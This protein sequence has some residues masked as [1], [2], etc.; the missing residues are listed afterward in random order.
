MNSCLR[1]LC[2]LF[3]LVLLPVAHSAEDTDLRLAIVLT[4][5][6][7][8]TPLQANEELD[9]YSGKPWP[10]W[11]LPPGMLTA[12]GYRQMV[13]MG[14][15]YR[16][17]YVAAGLLSGHADLDR[18]V[19]YFNADN[20]ARTIASAQGIAEGLM[21]GE[22]VA[23]AALPQGTVD[24][25][26]RPAQVP[27]GNPDRQLA[28]AAVLGSVGGD[29]ANVDRTWAPTLHDLRRVVYGPDGKLPPGRDP[30]LDRPTQILPGAG[31]GTV[32]LAGG[33]S[34]ARHV[35]ETMILEYEDGH[36]MDE[37]G[38]GRV[39]PAMLAE[40]TA[41]HAA[42]FQLSSGMFTAAQIQGSNLVSHILET[43][44]QAVSGQPRTGAFGTPRSRLVILA[45]HDTNIVNVAG[46][47]GLHWIIPGSGDNCP[48]PGGSLIFE[49]RQHRRDGRYEVRVLYV[50]Q[51]L[52]Q[53]RD[54]EPL[55]NAH[56][57]AL[58]ATFIPDCSSAE[59]GYPAPLDRFEA[60]LR[61]VINPEFVAPL[62]N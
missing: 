31:D 19:V 54:L 1:S 53:G 59:P 36:P 32:R 49:L 29:G 6:G 57:P 58:A 21:P 35:I 34:V 62:A 14:E 10:A 13:L 33:M 26:Y 38:W 8:R 56:P 41:L 47:L 16:D 43:I 48:L 20:D 27:V 9:R 51:T 7:V 24:P 28:A 45:G 2:L 12:H 40:F 44:D 11:S 50:A 25:L 3:V 55:S 37:V 30:G 4:R 23:V 18:E 22:K 52:E 61:R 17:R 15:Y 60:L 42:T 5:H 39:S 46:M